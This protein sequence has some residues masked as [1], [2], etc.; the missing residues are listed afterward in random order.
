[1]GIRNSRSLA[2]LLLALP[3]W[4][5]QTAVPPSV[6]SGPQPVKDVTE[7]PKAS[8]I[9]LGSFEF[10]QPAFL[11][12]GPGL[13][14]IE[15]EPVI[16]AESVVE[17][18]IYGDEA[19]ATVKFEAV[20]TNGTVLEPVVIARAPYGSSRFIGMMIVPAHPFRIVITGE[21]ID[22]QT[23][24]R[25]HKRLFRPIDR[26]DAR[27]RSWP[28]L[29]P[30]S[31]TLVQR[32]LDEVGPQLIA[33]VRTHLATAAT[34][35]I[36]MPRTRIFNVMYAPLFSTQGRPIG[37]RITYEA[38]FSEKGQYDPGVSADARYDSG[39]RRGFSRMTVL[40]STIAPMPRE[41]YPP[42]D[43]VL[44][45]DIRT[46]PLDAGAHYTY[47]GDTVYR[48][49]ADL[50]PNF[51]VHNLERTKSCIHYQ[52]Y[53]HSP[54]T[55]KAIAQILATETPTTYSVTVGTFKGRIQN[56]Y[57]EGTFFKSFVAEGAKDCGPTPTR[58]F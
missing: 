54:E 55:E 22:G 52:Q 34:G 36:V 32:S 37:L 41:A 21:A 12:A 48:F 16:G 57:G 14:R 40:D 53:T 8:E 38:K 45:N 49:T 2:V 24:R 6:P 3:V 5:V 42:H 7:P 27:P 11:H 13:F 33:D 43:E 9:S 4:V 58:R 15:G 47:E 29:S 25:A 44:L 30:E 56:F 50:V 10:Q 20:D 19:I 39:V 17:A 51:V 23:F 26:A 35:R 18:Y 46:S 28:G 1:M 31:A